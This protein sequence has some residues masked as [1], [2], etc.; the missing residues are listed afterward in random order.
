MRVSVLQNALSAKQSEPQKYVENTLQP[1]FK[2][3]KLHEKT[4]EQSDLLL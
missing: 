4:A 3:E 2:K 1:L